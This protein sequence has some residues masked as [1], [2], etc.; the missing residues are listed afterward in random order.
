MPDIF[1]AERVIAPY[2]RMSAKAKGSD[3][4][5]KGKSPKPKTEEDENR[6]STQG[7]AL[8]KNVLRDV[9]VRFIERALDLAA[10]NRTQAAHLLGVGRS[11]L[12]MKMR[13][14]GIA[15]PIPEQ[16]KRIEDKE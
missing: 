2:E 15:R 14:F 5:D 12:N 3:A 13:R 11:T 6:H 4:N 1:F 16:Y 10:N 7:P 8:L 9:E